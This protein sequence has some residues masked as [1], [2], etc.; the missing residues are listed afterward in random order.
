MRSFINV[1]AKN[2]LV[3]AAAN[4]V[5][6]AKRNVEKLPHTLR[7]LLTRRLHAGIGYLPPF[8]YGQMQPVPAAAAITRAATAAGWRDSRVCLASC[9]RTRLG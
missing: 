6:V 5:V 7:H 1:I 3:R 4:V 9:R 8:M 2:E